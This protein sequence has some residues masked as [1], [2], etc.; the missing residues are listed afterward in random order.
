MKK[1]TMLCICLALSLALSSCVTSVIPTP[2]LT[3]PTPIPTDT[4]TNTPIDPDTIKT[5]ILVVP[6]ETPTPSPPRPE[7]PMVFPNIKVGKKLTSASLGKVE[8]W[9]MEDNG[10]W[11]ARAFLDISLHIDISEGDFSKDSEYTW[12]LYFCDADYEQSINDN[13]KGP[14]TLKLNPTKLARADSVYTYRL[15]LAD[16]PE[17]DPTALLETKQDYCFLLTVNKDGKPIG[18]TYKYYT[19]LK[20][21]ADQRDIFF[22]FWKNRDRSAG[23]TSGKYPLTE[24]DRA[25]SNYKLIHYPAVEKLFT[26][27]FLYGTAIETWPYNDNQSFCPR[28]FFHSNLIVDS[29]DGDFTENIGKWSYEYT[30]EVYFHDAEIIGSQEN[31]QGP[32]IVNPHGFYR[33]NNENIMYRLNLGDSYSGDFTKNFEIGKTYMLLICVRKGTEVV[34]MTYLP[35]KWSQQYSDYRS[36]YYAFWERHDRSM[37]IK[38]GIHSVTKEDLQDAEK[39]Y[40]DEKGNYIP[41]KKVFNT[42][43]IDRI[44]FSSF[45]GTGSKALVPDSNMKEIIH[46]LSTFTVGEKV[47]ALTPAPGTNYN[48]VEI[49]YI[50]GS[51]INAGL[52]VIEID[53]TSYS[54]EKDKA[55]DCFWDIISNSRLP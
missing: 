50:N 9:P 45:Y 42:D 49:K 8:A 46:W 38:T 22:D 54:I 41:P 39:F 23:Y 6:T 20:G 31:I 25:Y 16:C 55:P 32:Y 48:F 26:N 7:E 24:N 18:Y 12:Q 21:Y 53:G 47:D 44:S 36:L 5:P 43:N 4:D 52:D 51:A 34:G 17:G 10:T 14:Y 2:F 19:W 11:N 29:K 40:F 15:S 13:L 28:A 35:L 27:S 30:W 33:F 3:T 1:I 37:G